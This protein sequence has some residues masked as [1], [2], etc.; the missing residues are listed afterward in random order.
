MMPAVRRK[1]TGDESA[2][3][4]GEVTVIMCMTNRLPEMLQ[5]VRRRERSRIRMRVA[6]AFERACSPS[7]RPAGT[8]L[9]RL[10]ADGK[11]RSRYDREGLAFRG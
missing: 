10:E 8:Y 11:I 6:G 9:C 4:F 7:H 5:E 2:G 3:D 1:Q